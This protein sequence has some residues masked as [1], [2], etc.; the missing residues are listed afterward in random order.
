MAETSCEIGI[1]ICKYRYFYPNE[2]NDS[3]LK[4]IC[5]ITLCPLVVKGLKVSGQRN[6]MAKITERSKKWKLTKTGMPTIPYLYIMITA[7]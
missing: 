6:V 5:S 2:K 1:K 3:N 4:A 7:V